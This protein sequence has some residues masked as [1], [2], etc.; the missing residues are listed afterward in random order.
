MPMPRRTYD[1]KQIILW[2]SIAAATVAAFVAIAIFTGGLSVVAAAIFGG[3]ASIFVPV[4]GLAVANLTS[5]PITEGE[6]QPKTWLG[7]LKSIGH[8][9]S[10]H[11]VGTS[12]VFLGTIL[13]IFLPRPL[14][15][16]G[17]AAATAG[18]AYEVYKSYSAMMFALAVVAIMA[19]I[20]L[21][22]VGFIPGGTIGLILALLAAVPLTLLAVKQLERIV[23]SIK[24]WIKN[25]G[26][27]AAEITK[28]FVEV[29]N[30][31]IDDVIAQFKKL[32]KNGE[33][34]K[35]RFNV[36]E[37][38]LKRVKEAGGIVGAF[39]DPNYA[40]KKE[41]EHLEEMDQSM[42]RSGVRVEE[43]S[44]THND[45]LD[46]GAPRTQEAPE[47]R[48]FQRPGNVQIVES[49]VVKT[50]TSTTLPEVR[51]F[52]RPGNVQIVESHMGRS[53]HSTTTTLSIQQPTGGGTQV[54]KPKV[55]TG[56]ENLDLARRNLI[57]SYTA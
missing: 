2:T 39:A 13:G 35:L 36:S 43:D 3:I 49:H 34:P 48:Q 12:A 9:V 47:V 11:K 30:E 53:I 7:R 44:L 41:A 16:V 10:E 40:D 33:T 27:S 17:G 31:T 15:A 38:E 4:T 32:D 45:F 37:S 18:I 29:P 1:Y 24:D 55:K 50:P 42:L 14:K 26:K 21:S 57:N 25:K 22:A 20:A 52:Q 46:L 28:E 51:Q 8:F 6:Q 5:K 56:Q 19:V 23:S 54:P